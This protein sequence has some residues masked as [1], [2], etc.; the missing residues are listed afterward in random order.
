MALTPFYRRRVPAPLQGVVIDGL[1]LAALINVPLRD[2]MTKAK[3]VAFTEDVLLRAKALVNYRL[4]DAEA[5]ELATAI[6]DQ[7]AAIPAED[8]DYQMVTEPG[9]GI[10]DARWWLGRLGRT[11]NLEDIHKLQGWI[12]RVAQQRYRLMFMKDLVQV[13]DPHALSGAPKEDAPTRIA[14]AIA[15]VK[16]VRS[17]AGK[18][19]LHSDVISAFDLRSGFRFSPGGGGRRRSAPVRGPGFLNWG[20]GALGSPPERCTRSVDILRVRCLGWSDFGVMNAGSAGPV[21]AA[22]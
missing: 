20:R 13:D 15:K 16:S 12:T 8:R 14:P 3:A 5:F 21:S 9:S 19:P 2:G 1:K 22:R 18:S 10:P 7:Y 4:T 11:L 17:V 6:T